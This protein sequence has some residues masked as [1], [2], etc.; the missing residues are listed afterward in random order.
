MTLSMLP[1]ALVDLG[2][3]ALCDVVEADEA[4]TLLI[5]CLLEAAALHEQLPQSAELDESQRAHAV[6]QSQ[7]A[8][9]RLREV[10]AGPLP[11][12]PSW[13]PAN[14]DAPLALLRDLACSLQRMVDGDGP[15][16]SHH[17]VRERLHA[18]RDD[19][20]AVLG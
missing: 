19:V 18:L 11:L 17:E 16:L 4:R 10:L 1:A 2:P 7:V 12:A 13:H 9:S 5:T 8:L 20:S 14:V 15:G 6:V 3:E